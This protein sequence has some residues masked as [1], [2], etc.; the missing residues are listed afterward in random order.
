MCSLSVYFRFR[1]KVEFPLSVDLYLLVHAAGV[2]HGFQ[3][4]D[5]QRDSNVLTVIFAANLGS[6]LHED[7]VVTEVLF[8]IIVALRH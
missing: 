8:S 5:R 2:L 1:P 3:V 6:Q 4:V 7:Y